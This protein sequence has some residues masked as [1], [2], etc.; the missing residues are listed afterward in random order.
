MLSTVF[1]YRCSSIHAK[2]AL[3]WKDNWN[4]SVVTSQ[5]TTDNPKLERDHFHRY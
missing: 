4:I 5:N 2:V 3:V 1:D